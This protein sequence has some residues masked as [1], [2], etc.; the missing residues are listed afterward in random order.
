MDLNDAQL[1]TLR[2]M[3]GINT[4][5]DRE[6]R[7]YRNYAA[8]NPG[9]PEFVELERIG[10]VERYEPRGPSDYHYYRCTD[11]GKQAAM[12]SHRAIRMPKAKRVY[13]RF[14]SVR[15][16]CPDLTFRE[17]LTSEDFADARRDA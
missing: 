13:A 10:A 5:R 11:A 6:P 16:L 17:Y 12:R 8:V 7:P 15:E 4:P 1:H 3:L 9:D 14:L 2:H